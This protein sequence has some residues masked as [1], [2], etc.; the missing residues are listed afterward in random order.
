MTWDEAYREVERLYYERIWRWDGAF[1][2]VDEWTPYQRAVVERRRTVEWFEPGK[3]PEPVPY[4]EWVATIPPC[5]VDETSDE[6]IE[7]LWWHM[8]HGYPE[9]AKAEWG[10]ELPSFDDWW[11]SWHDAEGE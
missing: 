11:A 5:D 2:S 10:P 7:R 4:D 6:A 9:K 3:D 8:G 1:S